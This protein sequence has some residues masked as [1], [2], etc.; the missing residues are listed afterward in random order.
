MAYTKIETMIRESN[1]KNI[2]LD[3]NYEIV[4]LNPFNN[5]AIVMIY[6]NDTD[7]FYGSYIIRGMNDNSFIVNY[8]DIFKRSNGDKINEPPFDFYNST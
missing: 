7:T 1:S 3:E 4:R 6:I 8:W 2:N 5:W